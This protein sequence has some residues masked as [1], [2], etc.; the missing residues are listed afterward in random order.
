MFILEKF[1]VAFRDNKVLMSV[2]PPSNI[3]IQQQQQQQHIGLL[4][5]YISAKGSSLWSYS[6]SSKTL[7][8]DK[9]LII[10]VSAEEYFFLSPM[11]AVKQQR[12]L[13]LCLVT[14]RTAGANEIFFIITIASFCYYDYIK[15]G[16]TQWHTLLF[17]CPFI[18]L[19]NFHLNHIIVSI[20]R[21]ISA[22]Q[23]NRCPVE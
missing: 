23:V 5:T 8:T 10:S 13:F 15:Y 16:C 22:W 18:F 14:C 12:T 1:N 7:P 20:H 3:I 9:E 2:G 4:L 17:F 19:N 11:R 6:D 21:H